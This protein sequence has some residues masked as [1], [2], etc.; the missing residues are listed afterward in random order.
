MK[1]LP[2]VLYELIAKNFREDS[3]LRK[4]LEEKTSFLKKTL[5]V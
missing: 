4:L 3:K 1:V 2:F 5:Q